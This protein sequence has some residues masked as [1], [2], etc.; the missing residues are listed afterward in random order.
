MIKDSLCVDLLDILR[1]SHQS[2]ESLVSGPHELCT[3]LIQAVHQ[4]GF[5][6]QRLERYP[7]LVRLL[8]SLDTTVLSTTR[9]RD[10]QLRKELDPTTLSTASAET[11]PAS[12]ELDPTT[13]ST[14][15]AEI[16]QYSQELETTT[17]SC[18]Q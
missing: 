13:L 16:R 1:L 12:Q 15:S 2:L 9:L 7:Q 4:L 5:N 6:T 18:N 3:K 10:A 8:K 11:R 17:R 14:A